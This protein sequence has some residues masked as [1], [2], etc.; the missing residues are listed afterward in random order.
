MRPG[1]RDAKTGTT[2]TDD[3]Q[4]VWKAPEFA[5][6]FGVNPALVGDIDTPEPQ[7][8]ALP[9]ELR[10]D[11]EAGALDAI[12]AVEV[13]SREPSTLSILN[14]FIAAK[15]D[16]DAHPAKAEQQPAANE[17]KAALAKVAGT[18]DAE[19]PPPSQTIA[20]ATKDAPRVASVGAEIQMAIPARE[21][22]EPAASKGISNGNSATQIRP[23]A[24]AVG[25]LTAD[26]VDRPTSV[27]E[28]PQDASSKPAIPALNAGGGGKPAQTA[29]TTDPLAAR[30]TVL[31][32]N[33]AVA[34]AQVV[35]QT[36][37]TTAGLV[38]AIESEPTWRAVAQDPDV[39]QRTPGQAHGVNSLK[40]QLNPAELG[41]VTARLT[42]SGTQLLIAVRVESREAHQKLTADSDTIIKALRAVGFDVEK[43]TIQQ[44]PATNSSAQQGMGGREHSMSN[45]QAQ[46]ENGA[47]Q[48]GERNAAG[49]HGEGGRHAPGEAPA[50]RSGS[51]LYI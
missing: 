7:A 5:K 51:D 42:T 23:P 14:A 18:L 12:A 17:A 29:P 45:Q 34:P 16:G 43:V 1:K 38:S 27:A 31:G 15:P 19:G 20:T 28:K 25:T 47:R 24:S 13:P 48:Q 46:S 50:D 3:K 40:I 26:A 32:S 44:A 30:V 39:L 6:R 2:D 36:N 22:Q 8:D 35:P 9:P 11:D 21:R 33:N 4:P 49:R 37:V 10:P 41:M